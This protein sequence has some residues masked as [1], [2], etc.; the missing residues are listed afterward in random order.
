MERAKVTPYNPE[1]EEA[2][3]RAIAFYVSTGGTISS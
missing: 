3:Q 2:T 1:G